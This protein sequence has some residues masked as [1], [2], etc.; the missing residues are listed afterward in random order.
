MCIKWD[1]EASSSEDEK[2]TTKLARVAIKKAS[3]FDTPSCLMDKA[4]R[5]N[6]I[7][8][9]VIVRMRNFKGSVRVM[10]P[11][12]SQ[13]TDWIAARAARNGLASTSS[14]NEAHL[15]HA[16][17]GQAPRRGVD[18]DISLLHSLCAMQRHTTTPLS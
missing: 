12:V 8:M 6:M 10:I 17:L 16:D 4:Q 18:H 15:S 14:A 7:V 5:Y 13:D 3:L 2:T 9:V 11:W 1:S